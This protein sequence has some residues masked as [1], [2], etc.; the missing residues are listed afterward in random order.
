MAQQK[1]EV[2]KSVVNQFWKFFT[3]RKSVCR[4]VYNN[5]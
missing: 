3:S 2:L 1:K 4:T 5:M